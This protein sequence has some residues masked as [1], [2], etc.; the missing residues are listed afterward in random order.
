[1]LSDVLKKLVA[2]APRSATQQVHDHGGHAPL[3]GSTG[4]RQ[5]ASV[6]ESGHESD[7]GVDDVINGVV[8]DMVDEVVYDVNDEDECVWSVA[9]GEGECSAVIDQSVDSGFARPVIVDGNDDDDEVEVVDVVEEKKEMG[10]VEVVDVVEEKNELGEAQ[11]VANDVVQISCLNVRGLFGKA[12][13]LL[14]FAFPSSSPFARSP[15][16]GWSASALQHDDVVAA[17][18]THRW[19]GAPR[20]DCYR[21]GL[22]F[23]ECGVSDDPWDRGGGATGDVRRASGGVGV[24]WPDGHHLHPCSLAVGSTVVDRSQRLLCLRVPPL[25]LCPLALF[26]RARS[27]VCCRCLWCSFMLP[28]LTVATRRSMV[29]GRNLTIG[30]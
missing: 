6:F 22:E 21:Q 13:D 11:V 27:V 28:R 15:S 1:M 7:H 26:L 12:S 25:L 14:D 16:S 17:V 3:S 2:A 18:E 10:E 8:D 20:G 5:S 24:W 4:W 29:S 19:S 30:W 9:E 23:V